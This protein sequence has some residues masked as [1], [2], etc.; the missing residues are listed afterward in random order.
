MILSKRRAE[1]KLTAAASGIVEVYGEKETLLDDLILEIDEHSEQE[2]AEKGKRLEK[3]EKLKE[4]GENIRNMAL[5]RSS[6]D[7]GKET[8]NGVSPGGPKTRRRISYDSDDE[9]TEAIVKDMKLR[10]EQEDRRF[11]LEEKRLD[12]ERKRA[13]EDRNR[14]DENR[15]TKRRQLALDERKLE[16]EIEERKLAIAER[17][18][19][20]EVLSGLA[21]KLK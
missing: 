1:V 3:E 18:K 21:D 16:I 15:D 6:R 11:K 12:L 20:L 2:R 8:T 7:M 9:T 17:T 14:F 5:K 4:A 13:E 19:M 10:R